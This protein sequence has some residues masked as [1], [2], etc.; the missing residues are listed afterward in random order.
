[1]AHFGVACPWPPQHTV[2]RGDQTGS[3]PIYQAIKSCQFE[4]EVLAAGKSVGESLIV[5]SHVG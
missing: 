4:T 2:M 3:I 5:F 1:M